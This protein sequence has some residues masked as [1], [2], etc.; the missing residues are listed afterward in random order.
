MRA[1]T[2]ALLLAM[3]PEFLSVVG[4][5][6]IPEGSTPSKALLPVGRGPGP[7]ELTMTDVLLISVVAQLERSGATHSAPA[8]ESLENLEASERHHLKLEAN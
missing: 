3:I 4:S 5:C 6:I 7:L 1:G 2:P 8:Q